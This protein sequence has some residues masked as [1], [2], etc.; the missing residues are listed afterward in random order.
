MKS[1]FFTKAK[2]NIKTAEI[3]FEHQLYNA[4]ANRA[5]YAAFQAAIAALT[6]MDI[7][8]DGI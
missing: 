6:A 2:E 1:E 7:V 3:L 5:Y 4:S 8:A